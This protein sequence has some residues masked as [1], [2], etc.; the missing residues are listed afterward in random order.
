MCAYVISQ[1]DHY[2]FQC[3]SRPDLEKMFIKWFLF[4]HSESLHVLE[5][6]SISMTSLAHAGNVV[7]MRLV[8][9][10]SEVVVW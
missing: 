6:F 3:V 4:A 7:C 10:M 8:S 1:L 5:C 2:N 9:I